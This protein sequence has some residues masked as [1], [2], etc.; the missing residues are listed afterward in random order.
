MRRVGVQGLMS[1]YKGLLSV[2]PWPSK[3]KFVFNNVCTGGLR[4]SR[5]IV[6]VIV[7]VM[8][9][10]TSFALMGIPIFKPWMNSLISKALLPKIHGASQKA[11]L[12]RSRSLGKLC[13][14]PP[15]KKTCFSAYMNHESPP[16]FASLAV[17]PGV[18]HENISK[19]S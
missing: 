7:I 10:R 2:K 9:G 1:K 4:K 19:Q 13:I 12:G 3:P 15:K 18:T 5:G 11:S 8:A 14:I 16:R 6:L 17:L